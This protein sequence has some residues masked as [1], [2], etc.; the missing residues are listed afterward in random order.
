LRPE[1]HIFGSC[2]VSHHFH[3]IPFKYRLSL[4]EG[5]L[6]WRVFFFLDRIG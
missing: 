1:S 4:I 5:I 3:F 6:L 2:W